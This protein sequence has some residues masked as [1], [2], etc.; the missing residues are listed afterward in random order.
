MI[1]GEQQPLVDFQRAAL[2]MVGAWDN[3]LR[4]A[5]VLQSVV[6]ACS[7]FERQWAGAERM[8]Q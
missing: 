3:D 6:R 2:K 8:T 1:A 5:A 4:A 7:A